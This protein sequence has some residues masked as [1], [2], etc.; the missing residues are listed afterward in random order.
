MH[1]LEHFHT[2]M[3]KMCGEACFVWMFSKTWTWNAHGGT[4]MNKCGSQLETG[5]LICIYILTFDQTHGRPAA[6]T[7]RKACS[8]CWDHNENRLEYSRFPHTD[9]V[10]ASGTCVTTENQMPVR[11]RSLQSS[12]AITTWWG[13]VSYHYMVGR[14]SYHYMVAPG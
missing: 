7:W 3:L 13:R 14:V 5:A 1:P 2:E 11:S 4:F 6:A 9:P 8:C 12:L 10:C